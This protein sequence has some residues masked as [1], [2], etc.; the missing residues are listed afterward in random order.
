MKI[1]EIHDSNLF[2]VIVESGCSATIAST[3]MNVAGASKTIYRCE[4]PYNKEYQ[5]QLYGKFKRSVSREWIK[6]VLEQEHALTPSSVNFILAS[7]WQLNDPNDPLVYA[8]GWIGLFDIKREVKHYLH[9][10][11]DRN[12]FKNYNATVDSFPDYSE[13]KYTY[14]AADR[15][16][17]LQIIGQLACDIL[18]TAINGDIKEL[19]PTN[20]LIIMDNAYIND[21]INYDLLISTLE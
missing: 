21:D 18:H 17:A 19:N 11:F 3:L 7:S 4:Q 9:F 1:Q 2:G 13:H 10:S 15:N 5:E 16:S 12:F 6:K 20:P 8:H 14:D